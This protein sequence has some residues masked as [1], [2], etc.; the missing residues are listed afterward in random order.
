MEDPHKNTENRYFV[1]MPETGFYI[2]LIHVF[3]LL[4]EMKSLCFENLQT[5]AI[6]SQIFSHTYHLPRLPIYQV[7][8]TLCEEND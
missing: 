3:V 5:A 1:T 7:R 8:T 2:G 6:Q 4:P